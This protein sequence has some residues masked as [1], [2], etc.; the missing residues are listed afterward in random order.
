MIALEPSAALRNLAKG[1][2]QPQWSSRLY[3]KDGDFTDVADMAD[4][5][6]DLV[7]ANLVLGEAHERE[8]ALRGLLRVTKPG[9]TVLATLPMYGTWSEPED[10]LR[11]VLRDARMEPAVRRLRRL[12]NLRPTGQE[13]ARIVGTLGVGP[14]HF[15]IEQERFSLLFRS[16]REFLF[17]PLVEHGPLRLWKAI[18]GD[19]GNPQELFWRLK[20]AIDAYYAG[21]VLVCTVVAGIL[22]LRVPGAGADAAHAAAETAGEYWRN[23]PE[24]DALWQTWENAERPAA[25]GLE[26]EIDIDIEEP[27][28]E[29]RPLPTPGRALDAEDAAILALLE[30]PDAARPDNELDALL[31]Q[32]LE[33]AGPTET[34]E[35]LSDAE[36]EEVP[37]EPVHRP[38]ETLKRIRAL[39]P[40]P[41]VVPPR[42]PPPPGR[43]AGKSEKQ[44]E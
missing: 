15:V 39:L 27:V 42:P 18:M 8:E 32:V 5:T 23:Y 26:V 16:G 17:S 37:P 12:A 33:F 43:P 31:D 3:L 22:V 28:E 1:H 9:G 14:D 10:L 24:L 7:V 6:Y 4:D 36:L 2:I 19:Q 20:E 13:L 34:V 11:E 35:E 25:A 30:Q 21:H 38:G 29:P 44:D 40:P 41:P